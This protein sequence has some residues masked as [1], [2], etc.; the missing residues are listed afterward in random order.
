MWFKAYGGRYRIYLKN[1]IGNRKAPHDMKSNVQI[2]MAVPGDASAVASVLHES[3]IEY[4]SFYTREGFDATT[5]ASDQIRNR[6]E[7]GPTWVALKDGAIVGTVSAVA[8]GEALYIRGMGV[9]P[10]ARGERIGELLL[11]RIES[12]AS[13]RGF[14]RLFLSTTPFLTRAIRLYENFGFKPNGEGPYE[15]FGTPLF[16]MEKNLESSDS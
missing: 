4:E 10:A 16:T 3:F 11:T 6:M 13:E 2:R 5:P 1:I 8:K 12:F 7:E 15:L 9:L 14:K